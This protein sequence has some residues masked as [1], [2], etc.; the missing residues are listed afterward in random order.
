ME[1]SPVSTS[2]YGVCAVSGTEAWAVGDSGTLLHRTGGVWQEESFPV[3]P[4]VDYRSVDIDDSGNIWVSGKFGMVAV[5]NGSD[6]SLLTRDPTSLTDFYDIEVVDDTVYIAGEEGSMW[7]CSQ[8][9]MSQDPTGVTV[10]LFR[11]HYDEWDTLWATGAD[12]LLM[13]RS[14]SGWSPVSLDVT[15]DIYT[16]DVLGPN[17]LW[18]AGGSSTGTCV[19]WTAAYFDGSDWTVYSDSGT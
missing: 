3:L 19:S 7:T 2:L 13:T 5:Y 17:S 6:W 8:G 10:P 14:G 18:I 12:G 15:D 11:V 4:T 9:I 16:I 1:T